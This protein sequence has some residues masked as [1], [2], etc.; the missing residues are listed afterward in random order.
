MS[1]SRP[2]AA[3][4]FL[5][6][7]TPGFKTTLVQPVSLASKRLYASGAWSSGSSYD[8]KNE[9]LAL[10]VS[11]SFNDYWIPVIRASLEL[12]RNHS[13]RTIELLQRSAPYETTPCVSCSS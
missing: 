12:T 5:A 10:P 6:S 4:P 11:M 3:W 7:A 2:G 9:G 13:E 1:T 8:T